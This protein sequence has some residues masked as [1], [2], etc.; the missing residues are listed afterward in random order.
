MWVIIIAA[1]VILIV[2]LKNNKNNERNKTVDESELPET[3]AQLRKMRDKNSSNFIWYQCSKKICEV[4][5][6]L[7]NEGK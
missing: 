2:A 4:G 6:E 5:M 1:I 3:L 7:D